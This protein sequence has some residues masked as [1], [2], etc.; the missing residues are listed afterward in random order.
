M[1][2]MKVYA[3]VVIGLISLILFL[4]CSRSSSQKVEDAKANLSAARQDVKDAVADS[5][6]AAREE[7]LTFKSGA[8][9]KIAANDKIVAEYKAKM[10]AANDRRQERSDKKIDM[11]EAKNRELRAKLYEYQEGGKSTW[12]QFQ[13]E[14]SHDMDELGTALKDFSVDNTK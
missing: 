14:F 1:R 3:L 9:A 7:W 2:T 4:G 10:A 5:Q 11:L 12:E 6:A 13:S 8:E